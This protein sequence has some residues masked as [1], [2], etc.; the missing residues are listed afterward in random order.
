MPKYEQYKDKKNKR[1][2]M[3]SGYIATDPITG[4]K[5]VTK[6][7]GF[8]TKKEA[9]ATFDQL[10]AQVLKG[11]KKRR[12][13]TFNELYNDWL[14]QHRKSVKP[15]TVATNRRFIEN[16]VLPKFG[17]L[18]L[19]QITVSYC[20]K[21]VNEWHDKFKQYNYMRRA[22]AQVMSYGVSMEL[23]DNNPMKKT[24]LPRKKED[25]KE[26]NFYNKDELKKFMDFI[27]TLDNYKY[28]AFFRL[29]AITGMR[30]SE[31]LALYKSDLNIFN[32]TLTIGKTLAID[33]FGTILLQEPKT[34]SSY[35]TISLDDETIR[36]LKHWFAIQ[37]EDYLK[38]GYNTTKG[39]QLMFSNLSN[40]L[41][42]PQ[43]VNDWL[44]WIY[45][46]AE[47]KGIELK[48]I[49]PHGFRHTAC[50]LMFESGATIN[51]VQKRLGHKDVKTTMNIYSHVTPKQAENTSDKLAKYLAF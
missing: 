33:E 12:S 20:Q 18:K 50:S 5:V 10:K 43:V 35:R 46:K 15:S 48:R 23:M 24:I 14:E 2:W 45:D 8:G 39:K 7:K 29:L 47:K 37:K 30:K 34:K 44:D 16:H 40:D 1:K 31:A 21:C 51:E 28:Y 22:A 27:K 26:P 19:D 32:K 4:K 25:N 13:I 6:R 41:F 36:V 17:K 11:S 38:L 3:F 9:I 42:Y 49:S